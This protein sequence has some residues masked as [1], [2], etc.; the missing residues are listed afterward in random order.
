MSTNLEAV[1][2]RNIHC[3][4]YEEMAEILQAGVFYSLPRLMPTLDKLLAKLP[5]S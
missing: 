4:S 3:L 1:S 5:E 2:H